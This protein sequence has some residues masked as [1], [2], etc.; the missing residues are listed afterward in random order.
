M[1]PVVAQPH[2]NQQPR[3]NQQ[4]K[5]SSVDSADMLS[6]RGHVDPPHKPIPAIS[7]SGSNP[8]SVPP[9]GNQHGQ[10]PAN[11]QGQQGRR[12][13]TS[14]H[15][16]TNASR[17]GY[18]YPSNHGGGIVTNADVST[19]VGRNYPQ[20]SPPT[21]AKVTHHSSS[22]TATVSGAKQPPPPHPQASTGTMYT[23]TSAPPHPHH[24]H[25]QPQQQF[26]GQQY[27]SG[28][29]SQAGVTNSSAAL[30]S[31]TAG[32]SSA[33]GGG[34]GQGMPSFGT[35]HGRGLPPV[36][37]G[38]A[39]STAVSDAH[40]QPIHIYQNLP[41]EHQM[42]HQPYLTAPALDDAQGSGPSSLPGYGSGG[43]R[44]VPVT[45]QGFPGHSHGR[46]QANYP[47]GSS[48]RD[49]LY[50]QQQKGVGYGQ[51]RSVE[52]DGV[53]HDSYPQVAADDVEKDSSPPSSLM[54]PSH[55]GVGAPLSLNLESMSQQ[56]PL[57]QRRRPIS[58]Q[59]PISP[60][61]TKPPGDVRYGGQARGNVV[62]A[63]SSQPSF[64]HGVV[65]NNRGGVSNPPP[66]SSHQLGQGG[67]LRQQ[68]HQNVMGGAIH[69]QV[70]NQRPASSFVRAPVQVSSTSSPNLPPSLMAK[71]AATMYM[72]HQEQYKGL[73]H[74]PEPDSE[75][76]SNVSTESGVS[77]QPGGSQPNL[78]ENT[79]EKGID[80]DIRRAARHVKKQLAGRES[81]AGA[82]GGVVAPFDPN[83]VCPSCGL[84]FR[85][86][87][88][89]K[90][91]RHAGTCTGR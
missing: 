84:R 26:G 11:Y 49:D 62:Q 18:P 73:S 52:G 48:S 76:G 20:S 43:L 17:G 51:Q 66:Q 67:S 54:P 19:G 33:V 80:G 79:L 70:L 45:G 63:D 46:Q 22:S 36:H 41:F 47:G 16:S 82:K 15:A 59:M 91:K 5:S 27:P 10:Q 24:H 32:R 75:A 34:S 1:H 71:Q 28:G 6:S 30:A 44:Q 39:H 56:G 3:L 14:S 86:G 38:P 21:N 2:S 7:I 87:E 74:V 42:Q 25:N 60:E 50:L 4:M 65:R 77:S 31:S 61:R 57:L 9:Y 13:Q 90:F 40:N 64:D 55:G 89:Q 81:P 53:H 83:L 85:I 8:P 12:S 58:H 72:P 68:P 78:N 23:Y 88:I 35:S 37:I 29:R 69:P